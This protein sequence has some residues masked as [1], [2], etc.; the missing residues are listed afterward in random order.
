MLLPPRRP[1]DPDTL[2]GKACALALELAERFSLSLR[3]DCVI[4]TSD[5]ILI[6]LFF[7]KEMGMDISRK[8]I[9]LGRQGEQRVFHRDDYIDDKE[10][11]DKVAVIFMEFATTE[12][13]GLY[14]LVDRTLGRLLRV[15]SRQSARSQ[16]K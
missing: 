2:Q 8:E 10:M 12:R 4:N 7:S 6:S 13:G 5:E 15:L 9:L 3:G 14:A 16:K 11:L 1:I